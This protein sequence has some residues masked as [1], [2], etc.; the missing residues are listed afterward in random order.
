M[1]IAGD[2]DMP[3]RR[4]LLNQLEHRLEYRAFR[5]IELLTDVEMVEPRKVELRAL[6]P[7]KVTRVRTLV[8]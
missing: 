4:R 3:P 5:V 7:L 6:E 8:R 1:R 2:L